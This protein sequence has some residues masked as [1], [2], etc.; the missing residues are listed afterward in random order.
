[1]SH[2]GSPS[3]LAR[4]PLGGLRRSFVTAAVVISAMAILWPCSAQAQLTAPTEGAP[5][6]FGPVSIYPSLSVVDIG[7]DSNVFNDGAGAKEDYTFTL[8]SRVM[9]VLSG[10]PNRLMFQTGS[11]FVWFQ[12]YKDE[13]S[14][15]GQYAL[16]ADLMWSRF[17]PFIAADRLRTRQRPNAEIDARAR[18][19]ER[20]V[21]AGIDYVVS[22]ITAITVSARVDDSHYEK[23]QEFREVELADALGR[24][25]RGISAGMKFALTPFTTLVMAADV[26]QDRF[27]GSPLR[28][29]DSVRFAPA[30]EFSR[31]AVISGRV[32]AGYRHFKPQDRTQPDFRGLTVLTGVTYSLLG[33]TRFDA[34]VNRDV[35]YSYVDT[36]AFFVNTGG[37]LEITQPLVGP[38]DLRVMAQRDRLFYRWHLDPLRSTST[39]HRDTEDVLSGGLQVRIGETRVGLAA[40]RT[41]R[42]STLSPGERNFDKMRLIGSIRVGSGS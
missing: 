7:S 37:R 36:E 19:T 11:D 9:T 29:S 17:K 31:E 20:S 39:T 35:S 16:R 14:S 8:Q 25:G 26:L 4:P 21:Q 23:G 22:P 34:F 2:E 33:R 3:Q 28:N 5:I 1:M 12:K 6:A 10:G 30:L 41:L 24:G 18:R 27:P 32:A 38:F 13:R 42:R 15:N 40:E